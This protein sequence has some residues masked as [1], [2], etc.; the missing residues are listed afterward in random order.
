MRP[1]F[2]V[3]NVAVGLAVLGMLV[4][5]VA[6]PDPTAATYAALAGACVLTLAYLV[7]AAGFLI[8]ALR[9]GGLLAKAGGSKASWLSKSSKASTRAPLK[10]AARCTLATRTYAVGVSISVFFILAAVG[11]EDARTKSILHGF[12]RC[13]R[14]SQC[15]Q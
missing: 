4:A 12:P 2:V 3:S 5:L 14:C 7:C 8:Y 11:E 6:A 1:L 9:L 13:W 15:S 10:R